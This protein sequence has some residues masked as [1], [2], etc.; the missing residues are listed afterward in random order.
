V[1]PAPFQYIRPESTDE[2]VEALEE[3]DDPTLLAGGQSLIATMNGRLATPET[4]VDISYVDDLDYIR[5]ENGTIS[6][7]ALTTQSTAESSE[8]VIEHC[9][10][11]AEALSNVG[12]ETIRNKGTIGGNLAHADPTSELPSVA[13]LKGATFVLRGPD[14]ERVVDAEDFFL[15]H[16]TTDVRSDEMLTEIRFPTLPD[17]HGWSFQ[18]VAPVEGGYPIVGVAATLATDGEACQHPRI[19]YTAVSDRPLR[20]PD[21]ETEVE[22]QPAEDDSFEAAAEIAREAVNPPSDVHGSSDY[23]RRLVKRLTRDAL[24]QSA[25]RAEGY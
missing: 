21:V 20:V 11:V 9:P 16:L 4:M 19:A 8:A 23:R 12:H 5:T 2:A 25:E 15:G 13:L 7:G 10:L 18:E 14:G 1:K 6:I 24:E 3:H 17:G 22:G